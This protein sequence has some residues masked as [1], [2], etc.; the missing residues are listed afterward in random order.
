M[1]GA[2]LCI[3]LRGHYLLRIPAWGAVALVAGFL[4]IGA[5]A[6]MQEAPVLGFRYYGAIEGRVVEVDRS[7]GDHLRLTLDRVVLERTAPDRTPEKVRVSLHGEQ[8]FFTPQAGAR[9][10]LTGHLMPP[11]PPSQPGGFDFRRMAWFQQLGALG[12]TQSPVLLLAPPEPATQLVNRLRERLSAAV[13][14]HID[15]QAGAFASGSVTGD[16]SGITQG[17]VVALRDSNLS[18]LLAI[19]GMNLAFL[20]SFVFAVLRFG[21]ALV[22]VVALRVNTKK[23]AAVVAV[24]VAGFYLALSGGNIAT[25]RAF[26]MSA[27]MLGAVLAD[28]RALSMR[29]AA[30][31][32]IILLALQPEALINAGFQMSMAATVGL[33]WGFGAVDRLAFRQRLPR[34]SVPVYVALLSSVI[35][36]LAT[37]PIAAAQFN[38]FADF[39]LLANLLTVPAMGL[40]IMPGAVVAT[41][42]APFGLPQPGM[43]MMEA[44]ARWIL[45]VAH[46]VAGWEGAVTGIPAPPPWV[47]PALVLGMAWIIV[48]P[49]RVRL[50]GVLPMAVAL[51]GWSIAERPAAL[52]A[53]D[54]IL[55]G[56]MGDD[57]RSLSY[58]SGG[59]FV[60]G[61]W[62]RSDGDLAAQVVAAAR[63]GFREVDG[64]RSGDLDGLVLAHLKGK[65]APDHLARACELA[66]VVV[67][68]ARLAEPHPEG[69]RVI[70]QQELSRTGAMAL[71][72]GEGG[73]VIRPT[74]AT[75]RVWDG[76]DQ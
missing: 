42:L 37:G 57:G 60:A 43:W 30:L 49:Q 39:G 67:I 23:I 7:A 76:A 53:A 71:S 35:G 69:C 48:W 56:I 40:L 10:I 63:D 5:R 45:A 9:V 13:S 36:G 54:G 61:S 75:R 72:V 8:S 6:W 34:W 3:A 11:M 74:L 46:W 62:L 4:L 68:A 64:I 32:G 2:F 18:H 1:G 66:D 19:S 25:E 59:S 15:G 16:R 44:G 58:P 17:T 52:V 12:Y 24:C 22:P 14:S 28:R 50:L 41:L 51:A 31:S 65:A 29:T 21:L 47:L 33:I 26:I 55:V 20:V 73:L 38:R 70:D 27:I